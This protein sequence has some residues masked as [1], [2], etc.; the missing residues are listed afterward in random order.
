MK[1]ILKNTSFIILL[2]LITA[3]NNVEENDNNSLNIVTTIAPL[4]DIIAT[5]GGNRIN[6]QSIVPEGVNSHTFEPAP[7]DA[8]ALADADLIFLNGLHLE[9][10]TLNLA[11]ANLGDG[12]EI[13]QLGEQTLT[14]DAYMYDFSFPE[15]GGSPNPHL[16]TD[17]FLAL[18][19]AAIIR[20]KLSERD[21]ENRAFYADNYDTFATQ[22]AT[23][24]EGIIAA[25]ASIPPENRKLLTYHDS[26]AYFA[27][28][29]GYTIIGAI[30]PADFSQ[31]S[32]REMAE[33]IDQL[34]AED[35]P[36]IFG[37]EIFP[38]AA[39]DQIRREAGIAYVNTLRDDD[40][41]GDIGDP[42]HTYIGMMV[43]NVRTMT[44]ALGGDPSLLPN[45]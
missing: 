26:F 15:S 41:P 42:N 17:P 45:P 18:E 36:A 19:Y 21:P 22:I 44:R 32:A 34:K 35:I 4:T 13:I 37:S 39:L 12:A 43:E 28:R 7:S 31:P 30:Q 25:T 33:L 38:S 40:L 3:C 6:L 23:L 8:V 9:T 1:H 29:Y 11:Q 27:P 16:W 14:P 2:I 20:N 24:D 5:I 10:P